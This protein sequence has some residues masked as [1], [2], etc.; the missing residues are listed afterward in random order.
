MEQMEEHASIP[1]FTELVFSIARSRKIDTHF[2]DTIEI[3]HL[4]NIFHCTRSI[5]IIYK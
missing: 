1:T 2:D 3:G 5:Q 4:L